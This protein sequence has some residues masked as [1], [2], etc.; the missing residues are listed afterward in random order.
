MYAHIDNVC[1]KVL[2]NITLLIQVIN[3]KNEDQEGEKQGSHLKK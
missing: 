3:K 1:L 2:E